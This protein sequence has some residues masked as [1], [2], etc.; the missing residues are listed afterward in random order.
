MKIV[1]ANV[2]LYA[3]N[4]SSTHHDAAHRWLTSALSGVEAVALPWVSLLA[5]I[6]ISTNPRVFPSPLP[7]PVA[8]EL[9]ESWLGQPPATALAQTHR[10][11]GILRDLLEH[12]GTGGNLTTDAHLA[13]LAIEH[14]A[15][16][17]SF[18]R[19][20]GRFAVRVLVPS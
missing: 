18:D 12:A 7:I 14:G 11:A 17:V 4:A 13:A 10:H 1:D 9:V 2:L 3:T 5:F 20:L 16:I 19:D 8:C 6:R 15:E